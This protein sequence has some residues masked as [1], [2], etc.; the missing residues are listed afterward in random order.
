MP[1]RIRKQVHEL[2]AADLEAHPCWEY[3]SDEEGHKGQDECTVRPLDPALVQSE[4]GQVFVQTVFFFPNG[5]VRLGVVTLNAG[6]SPSGHQPVLFLEKENLHFYNGS[7]EPSKREVRGFLSTLE[8][9]SPAPFPIR[10]VSS[11]QTPEGRP[12]AYGELRGLYWLADWR[13]HELRTAA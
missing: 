6:E 10:Y 12:L 7:F 13:T 1:R 11:L 8:R 4:S 2:R 9:I 3:A 5:R